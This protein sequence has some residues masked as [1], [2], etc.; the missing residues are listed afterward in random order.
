MPAIAAVFILSSLLLSACSS[1]DCPLNNRVFAKYKISG[2]TSIIS[3]S[4]TV[5]A[6]LSQAEGD[7]TVLVNK[8]SGID[9]LNI[10]MSYN[11]PEDMLLF[12]VNVKD[13][14]LSYTDTVWVEKEDLPHF[15]SID[16]NPSFFHTIKGVRCT[17]NIIDSIKL[18]NPNVT[19]NDAKAHF[20][21]YFKSSGN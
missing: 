19:Y 21:I 3:D 1:I 7:D 15:E 8:S 9:S 13:T 20:I 16:C 4:I 17:H 2:D 6:P 14:T 11:H 18:N 12:T 5:S 10:P